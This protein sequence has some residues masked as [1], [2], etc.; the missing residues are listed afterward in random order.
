MTPLAEKPVR[1]AVQAAALQLP[2]IFQKI[3]TLKLPRKQIAGKT[4]IK[5]KPGIFI[6]AK[7]AKLIKM[8]KL[9]PAILVLMTMNHSG[10]HLATVSLPFYSF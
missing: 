1:S 2:Q 9:V 8:S 7:L 5:L 10:H 4:T 3:I 6:Q